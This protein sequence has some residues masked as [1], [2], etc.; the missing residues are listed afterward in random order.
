MN[1]IAGE[2]GSGKSHLLKRLYAATSTL[3]ALHRNSEPPSKETLQ[4]KLA[5]TYSRFFMKEVEIAVRESGH[6]GS[7]T[8]KFFNLFKSKG[9]CCS[10][11]GRGVGDLQNIV[12][13]QE[14]LDQD[15]RERA[16][17]INIA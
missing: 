11:D 17:G 5:E 2:N 14:V 6:P 15:D 7:I 13:L 4:R 8:Q 3:T 12:N 16:P 10:E 9:S 1:V